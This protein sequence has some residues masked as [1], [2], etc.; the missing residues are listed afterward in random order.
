MRM[1]TARMD[2][3]S[4]HITSLIIQNVHFPASP[5]TGGRGRREGVIKVKHYMEV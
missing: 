3:P 4:H 2:T 5:N 1:D